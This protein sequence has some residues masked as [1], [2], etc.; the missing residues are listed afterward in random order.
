M[1]FYRDLP[2]CEWSA[3]YRRR[4]VAGVSSARESGCALSFARQR[5]VGCDIA[6]DWPRILFAVRAGAQES[7]ASCDGSLGV[8]GAAP[9][10]TYKQPGER[11]S[12]LANL[13]RAL[14]NLS[15]RIVLGVFCSGIEYV[16]TPV[17]LRCQL[18]I[19]PEIVGHLRI[20][21][22]FRRYVV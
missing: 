4:G 13:S 22:K 11:T 16:K 12:T 17:G 8:W 7:L 10:Y 9:L 19:I 14:A 1:V 15:R 18:Q 6:G 5:L 20:G 2:V 3:D 21:D